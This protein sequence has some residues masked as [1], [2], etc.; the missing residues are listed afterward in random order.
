MVVAYKVHPLTWKVFQRLRTVKWV[1]LVNLV[2]EREVVPE[3]LQDRAADA[4]AGGRPSG[5]CSTRPTLGPSSSGKVWPWSG[6]VWATPARRPDCC[7][8]GE[9]LTRVRLKLSPRAVAPDR[10]S[11]DDG[12]GP[13]W[14]IE[15]ITRS[16]GG[17]II[18]PVEPTSTCS[19]TRRCCRCSGN[20]G[21]R[22]SPSW[23]ARRGMA[24]IWPILPPRWGTGRSVA[25]AP[26]VALRALLGSGARAPRRAV[27]GVHAGRAPGAAARAQTRGHG[28]G[29][30]RECH[31]HS[32]PRRVRAG[33][34]GYILGTGS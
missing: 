15:V 22:A 32:G 1:S 21:G 19:G 23:S 3:L 6:T 9:L 5:R 17:E 27:C 7:M 28:S 11:R 24:S 4:G 13:S 2:A 31:R 18:R 10:R 8:A 29:A 30:A 16:A 26:A 12:P 33:F 20:T 25:R 34:G 14:R